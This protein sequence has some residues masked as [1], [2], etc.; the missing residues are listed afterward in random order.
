MQ[1]YS[2]NGARCSAEAA[3]AKSNVELIGALERQA[4]ASR[5]VTERISDA[6]VRIT[7]NFMFVLVHLAVFST[8]IVV[9]LGLLPGV[10][11]FDPFP[12]GI[13][14]LIV[15]GEGVFLAIFV[16]ISQNR[17]MRDSDRRAHLDLQMSLLTEQSSAKALELLQDIARHLG[18]DRGQNDP[19]VQQL[20]QRTDVRELASELDRCLPKA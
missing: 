16:L 17:M 11:P 2:D 4:R 9:N 10:T 5:S 6:I 8:W 13:L 12:F 7:G 14:T 18:I 20:A 19:E 15:S 1:A 3:P